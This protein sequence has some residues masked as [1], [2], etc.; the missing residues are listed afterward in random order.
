M[1][2]KIGKITAVIGIVTGVL[3]VLHSSYDF[4]EKVTIKNHVEKTNTDLIGQEPVIAKTI[5]IEP[6]S[7]VKMRVDVSFKI[8]KTGDIIIESGSTR[9]FLPF[10]LDYKS[11]SADWLVR[12]AFAQDSAQTI[13]GT[14]YRVKTVKYTETTKKLNAN[15]IEEKRTYED[16]TVEIKQIDVRSNDILRTTTYTVKLTPREKAVIRKSQFTKDVFV[17]VAP[18]PPARTGGSRQ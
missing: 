8:F 12:S 2:G 5:V 14:K 13:S 3:A 9:K 6:Q 17:E 10:A 11:A 16:G 1:A 18:Q 15:T 4:Y 7:K